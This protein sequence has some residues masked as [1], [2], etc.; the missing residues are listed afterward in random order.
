MDQDQKD[1]FEQE[2]PDIES[3]KNTMLE[4]LA[5]LSDIV[6]S[7]IDRNTIIK[8]FDN[9][10]EEYEK[11]KELDKRWAY[12]GEEFVHK[13]VIKNVITSD[14]RT[15]QTG[16]G[17]AYHARLMVTYEAIDHTLNLFESKIKECIRI[18]R[19]INNNLPFSKIKRSRDYILWLTDR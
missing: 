14:I 17:V 18:L 15:A 4:L 10:D 16:S 11:L 3:I 6:H 12:S 5:K 8:N 2:L 19:R 7:V 13:Y 1:E 9:L